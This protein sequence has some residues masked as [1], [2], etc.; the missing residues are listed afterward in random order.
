MHL[1]RDHKS[2]AF[3]MP[4]DDPNFSSTFAPDFKNLKPYEQNA[5]HQDRYFGSNRSTDG[6]RCSIWTFLMQ[7]REDDYQQ[8]GVLSTWGYLRYD[9]DEDD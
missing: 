2:R 3:F 4:F 8:I 9:S 1:A 6:L 5:N 7:C